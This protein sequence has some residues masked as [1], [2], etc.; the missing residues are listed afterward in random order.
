MDVEVACDQVR[1]VYLLKGCFR[2]NGAGV[3][4]SFPGVDVVKS[5]LGGL[6]AEAP[7]WVIYVQVHD[8]GGVVK[9]T[10]KNVVASTKT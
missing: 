5:K 3:A 7:V 4:P 8:V 1:K 2:G 6:G 9:K 10:R